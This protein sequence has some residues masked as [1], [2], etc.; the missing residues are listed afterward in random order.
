MPPSNNNQNTPDTSSVVP[1]FMATEPTPNTPS[2]TP[3]SN[4]V[5]SQSPSRSR[6]NKKSGL[7][8][9]GV[10]VLVIGMITSIILVTRQQR[11]ATQAWD[12]SK[13]IFNVSQTGEVTA[14]LDSSYQYNSEKAQSAVVS[15][16]G[17]AIATLS[18]PEIQKGQT[19]TIG[20]VEV[21]SGSFTWNVQGESDCSNNGNYQAQVVCPPIDISPKTGSWTYPEKFIYKNKTSSPITLTWEIKC[22]T[23]KDPENCK[24]NAPKDEMG[25][26]TL[27]PGQTVER[28]WG[29]ICA[30][31]QLDFEYTSPSCS[32]T[33]Y[34]AQ[35][36]NCNATPTKTPTPTATKTPTPTATKTPTPTA[37]K[38]PT[39]STTVTSTPIPTEPPI[40]GGPTN[41]P[42]PTEPPTASNPNSCNGTCGSDANCQP[43]LTCYM[44]NCRNPNNPTNTSCD[45]K[46]TTST[47]TP[48]AQVA[49]TTTKLPES[50]VV[51][52]TWA[53]AIAGLLL[54]G[55]GTLLAK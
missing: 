4:V 29:P 26:E 27:Q 49:Q 5:S 32:T 3:V 16:N 15:I 38:T 52:Y 48:A 36:Q 13:Y 18:V 25:T 42:R 45:N 22:Q 28:G 8:I 40:G 55:F 43:G 53:F 50:G 12:C 46:A 34:V 37:T 47:P 54:V 10:L 20:K 9:G 17:Q 21:P 30:S 39:P 31:W 7:A 35:P 41:T 33:G 11:I 2:T 51:E 14:K 1:A 19:L 44:G 6:L 23:D 24:K